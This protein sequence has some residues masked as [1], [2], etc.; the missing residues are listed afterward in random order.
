MLSAQHPE[1]RLPLRAVIAQTALQGQNVTDGLVESTLKDPADAF[2]FA[3][4]L[5]MVLHRIDVDRKLAFALKVV[6]WIF[7]SRIHIRGIEAKPGSQCSG[8]ALGIK[9]AIR[10]RFV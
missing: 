5:Q 9:R 1:P 3:G 4:V 10:R 8:E 2:T 7:K 6:E